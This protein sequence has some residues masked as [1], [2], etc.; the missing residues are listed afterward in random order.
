MAFCAGR[1]DATGWQDGGWLDE[2]DALEQEDTLF[3]SLDE[4][5]LEPM[6]ELFSMG[7]VGADV[8]PLDMIERLSWDVSSDVSSD[9]EEGA[10]IPAL[11]PI[12][13]GTGAA[14]SSLQWSLVSP[15]SE[16]ASPRASVTATLSP[17]TRVSISSPVRQLRF[18]EPEHEPTE[19]KLDA[20]KVETSGQHRAE[21]EAVTA[22]DPETCWSPDT[23]SELVS[24]VAK[25]AANPFPT[26]QPSESAETNYTPANDM[27][28]DSD[29]ENQHNAA[30]RPSL[31]PRVP[32]IAHWRRQKA[33]TCSGAGSAGM[34]T[35]LSLATFKARTRSL[36]RSRNQSVDEE[37]DGDFSSDDEGYAPELHRRRASETEP[38]GAS[39]WRRAR[40]TSMNF[41][42]H[43]LSVSVS[44]SPEVVTR[45]LQEAKSKISSGL[46]LL[47]SGSSASTAT[48]E[49]SYLL[50]SPFGEE[51]K[52][53]PAGLHR[54]PS[55]FSDGATSTSLISAA[56]AYPGD[57]TTEKYH[58]TR[59]QQL[60]AGVF[61]AAGLINA[62]S[63]KL[64]SRGFR[65]PHLP[66]QKAASETEEE[67]PS[68]LSSSCPGASPVPVAA[69]AP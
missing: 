42:N 17:L 27:I 8:M 25:A 59:Q 61:R 23:D 65:A 54:E 19:E 35:A 67:D 52:S 44:M 29:D 7:L 60:R 69:R 46:H 38:L 39:Q 3:G 4:D 58:P 12:Q 32:S 68:D 41:T 45:R 40:H 11:L 43:R 18:F 49:E 24:P 47:R 14:D 37:D 2:E 13:V 16:T 57:R 20:E 31:L 53:A 30:L 10:Q 6:A 64:K 9:G 5:E 66:R 22:F 51:I 15:C 21:E 33:R 48:S 63:A 56:S 50:D 36:S 62:A 26:Y 28:S 34:P 55:I 1:E